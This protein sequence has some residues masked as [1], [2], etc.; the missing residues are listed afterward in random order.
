MKFNI[1]LSVI[2]FLLLTCFFVGGNSRTRG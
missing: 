2:H 1:F